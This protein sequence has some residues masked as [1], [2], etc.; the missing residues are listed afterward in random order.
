MT[1]FT[2]DELIVPEAIDAPGGADF[3]EMTRVRNEIE[4]DSAGTYDLA[5]HPEELLP[6]WQAQQYEPK[7]LFVA[8]VEGRIVARAI[9]ETNAEPTSPTAWVT[10][11][12]LRAFRR[13][14][15]GA[16]LYGRL[17]SIAV[18]LGKVVLQCHVIQGEYDSI[19]RI[20]APTG[21]GSVPRGSPATR[22]LLARGFTLEQVARMSRLQLP[23]DRERIERALA[24]AVASVGADYRLVEWTGRTPDNRLEQ[25]AT[26]RGR[27]A[28]D[29]PNAGLEPD[30][31]P[32]TPD[33]VRAEDD[34]LESSPRTRL[35]ILAEHGPTGDAAGYTELEVPRE[36]SRP[37]AQGDTIVLQEHRGHRLGMALKLANLVRVDDEWPGRPSIIT[38]N[39][40]ENRHMLSVNEAIGFV[41]WGYEGAWRKAL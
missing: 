13:R 6:L 36:T 28:T 30:D 5:V 24:T 3:V 22:F 12:V 25:I 14:G 17:E 11:E 40:E 29:A 37:I 39:A 41:P 2:I 23:I 8:R 34:A 33:R 16:A 27:M 21:Y 7:R 1:G 10:V 19:E 32:W 18:E 31:S 9:I 26:L 35:T 38:F 20:V 4:A 15:I